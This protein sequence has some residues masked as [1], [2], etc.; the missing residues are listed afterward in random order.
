MLVAAMA[1]VPPT[2]PSAF[3]ADVTANSSGTMAGLPVGVQKFT[4]LYDFGNKRL[5][6]DLPNGMTKLY[7]YDKK[8]DP[9]LPVGPPKP[10][11]PIAPTPIAYQFRTGSMQDCCW[12]WLY[13]KDSQMADKMFEIKI[14]PKSKDLGPD[15]AH[16]GAEHWQ[17]TGWF[18]FK[19]A[20]DDYVLNGT[21]LQADTFLSIKSRGTAVSNT[22]YDN[23]V[24]GPIDESNFDHPTVNPSMPDLGKCKQFGVDPECHAGDAK[25]MRAEQLQFAAHFAAHVQ[26]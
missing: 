3:T 7:R 19:T 17:K 20:S 18:P 14:D 8:V 16:G 6:K 15:A 13:D 10:G 26:Q 24:V 1:G 5:R 21:L 11:V 2:V 25:E 22:T 12:L 4:M 9:P 23:V